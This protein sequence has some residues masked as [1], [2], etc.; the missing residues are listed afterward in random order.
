MIWSCLVFFFHEVKSGYVQ[1]YADISVCCWNVF[2][3]AVEV[4]SIEFTVLWWSLVDVYA[5]M[6]WIPELSYG[7]HVPTKFCHF[8]HTWRYRSSQKTVSLVGTAVRA[9]CLTQSTEF[10]IHS[11]PVLFRRLHL[12]HSFIVAEAD[13]PQNL[14]PR[15]EKD[16]SKVVLVQ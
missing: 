8:Y 13:E 5:S 4:P 15:E 12:Q 7:D 11:G 16:I 1:A 9:S 10:F 6:L 3:L 14:N 2:Y